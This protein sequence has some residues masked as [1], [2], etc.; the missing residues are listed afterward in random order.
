MRA[1]AAV[2][3]SLVPG[4]GELDGQ[5]VSV[6][7]AHAEAIVGDIASQVLEFAL[8]PPIWTPSHRQ[9]LCLSEGHHFVVVV[10]HT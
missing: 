4:K 5:P 3:L 7:R 2:D 1:Q 10:A 8:A 6:A 9:N